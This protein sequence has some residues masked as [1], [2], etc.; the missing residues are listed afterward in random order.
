MTW[1]QWTLQPAPF[2]FSIPSYVV[3]GS[4]PSHF[5]PQSFVLSFFAH[6]SRLFPLSPQAFSLF[7]STEWS[8]H[9]SSHGLVSWTSA[10]TDRSLLSLNLWLL[11]CLSSSCPNSTLT[12]SSALNRNTGCLNPRK[13]RLPIQ[14]HWSPYDGKFLMTK[15]IVPSYL[16]KLLVATGST[17]IVFEFLVA[18]AHAFVGYFFI[19]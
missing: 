13:L 9:A 1:F 14:C 17:T 3:P 12:C 11:A 5:Y 2:P 10:G 18:L 4:L 19:C 16:E 6:A 8:S 15:D 7:P